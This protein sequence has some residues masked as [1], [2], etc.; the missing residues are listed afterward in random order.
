MVNHEMLKTAE[1]LI[2]NL[3]VDRALPLVRSLIR[4]GV[5][6]AYGMPTYIYDYKR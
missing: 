3:E 1:N 2:D 5:A 6:E 4:S